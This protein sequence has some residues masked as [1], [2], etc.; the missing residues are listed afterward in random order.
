MPLTYLNQA[1]TCSPPRVSKTSWYDPTS[2]QH[3]DMV[4][5]CYCWSP[6]RAFKRLEL[7]V[8][9]LNFFFLQSTASVNCQIVIISRRLSTV[10][11]EY[12]DSP[13]TAAVIRMI[14]KN[15]KDNKR[16]IQTYKQYIRLKK[17]YVCCL[18]SRAATI[19]LCGCYSTH[20]F[21]QCNA[22]VQLLIWA[23]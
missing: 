1:Q 11:T 18:L 13:C 3:V 22:S 9:C 2:S 6:L 4:A 12:C 10:K 5:C 19:F 8:C 21:P 23:S 17:K 7:C 15:S 16:K 14:H 20:E